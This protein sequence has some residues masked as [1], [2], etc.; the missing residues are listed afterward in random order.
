M[1]GAEETVSSRTGAT[2]QEV[3]LKDKKTITYVI[4][5]VPLSRARK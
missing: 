2:D 4:F 5:G 3:V 1:K